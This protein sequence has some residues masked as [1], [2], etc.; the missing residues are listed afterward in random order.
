MKRNFLLMTAL[1]CTLLFACSPEKSAPDNAANAPAAENLDINAKAAQILAQMTLEEKIGQI[2]QADISAVTPEEVRDYNLGSVLNGGNS[3]PGGGKV[4]PAED[5]IALADAFWDASTDKSDGG[6]GIPLL[7]GTDAVHGHNNL[8]AATMFPHNSALGATNNPEL[9]RD[10]GDVTAREI[11]ATG[12]DWTF[13]PTLAVAIDDRWGRAYES[14]SENPA[15]VAEYAGAI[16]EGL[17][18]NPGDPD[19]LIGD[20]VMATAKH[21]RRRWRHTVWHR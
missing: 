10:I 13:A 15:L 19:Y 14:Y 8:Q 20:N 17:Q 9:M 1:S 6:V 11:R 7:W 16:V 12:L 3:A 2:L 5:W 18:G 21:F 4:A